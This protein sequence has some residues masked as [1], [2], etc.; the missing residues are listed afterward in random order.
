VK[1]LSWI[2]L[3]LYENHML[4]FC[5]E[6]AFAKPEFMAHYDPWRAYLWINRQ[7]VLQVVKG[8]YSEPIRHALFDD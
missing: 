4:V 1:A 2:T 7:Q 6:E 8:L 3:S 5:F